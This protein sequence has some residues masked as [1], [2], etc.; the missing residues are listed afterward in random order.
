MA[1]TTLRKPSISQM[2]I[3]QC[4]GGLREWKTSFASGVCDQKM[5]SMPNAKVS[6]VYLAMWTV[7]VGVCYSHSQTSL[8]KSPSLKNTTSRGHICDFYSK[9]HRE[10]NFIEQYW[11]AVKFHYHSSPKTSDF[12]PI[13]P[14]VLGL[15]C[16]RFANWSGRFMSAYAQ[17]LSGTE[18]VW[19]NHKYHG[20]HTLPLDMVQKAKSSQK[21][22]V[23]ISNY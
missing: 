5:G 13:Y 19:A 8:L 11:G 15:F 7:A 2:T 3:L 21:K 10:L 4:L 9:F 20:H 12:Y 23:I 1:L 22:V 16:C 17:G 6:S 18:A 14:H